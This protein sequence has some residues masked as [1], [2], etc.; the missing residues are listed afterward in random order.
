LVPFGGF[1]HILRDADAR[2]VQ[3][4][5]SGHCVQI[6]GIGGA[7]VE[8]RGALRIRGNALALEVEAGKL[9]QRPGI[10]RLG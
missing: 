9:N 7:S 5:Q 6:A 10:A 1:L 2:R 4:A 3:V 8:L